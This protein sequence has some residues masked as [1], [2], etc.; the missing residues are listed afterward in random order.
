MPSSPSCSDGFMLL[1]ATGDADVQLWVAPWRLMGLTE[2][3]PDHLEVTI[4]HIVYHADDDPSEGL[5]RLGEGSGS[6]EVEG[7]LRGSGVVHA[8]GGGLAEN[9]AG[10]GDLLEGSG[11]LGVVGK[12]TLGSRVLWG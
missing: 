4:K 12:F 9:V 6:E 1:T 8:F 2:Q 3:R 10:D 11:G 5:L 7:C